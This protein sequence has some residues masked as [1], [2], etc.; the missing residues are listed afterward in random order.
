[1]KKGLLVIAIALFFLGV[2]NFYA[3]GLEQYDT[4][5]SKTT[6]GNIR[7]VNE[8]NDGYLVFYDI[9]DQGYIGMY[10]EAFN[11]KWQQPFVLD[12]YLYQ[13][14][15]NQ[16]DI[17]YGIDADGNYLFFYS[18]NDGLTVLKVD[19]EGNKI[20]QELIEGFDNVGSCK[21][22]KVDDNGYI[23]YCDSSLIKLN[24]KLKFVGGITR[25]RQLLKIPSVA[26][27]YFDNITKYIKIDNNN[28]AICGYIT[29]D[30]KKNYSCI[31]VT[32]DNITEN[33]KYTYFDN[34]PV[35]SYY[36]YDPYYGSFNYEK[37]HI[38]ITDSINGT[39][40]FIKQDLKGNEIWS[41]SYPNFAGISNIKNNT[42]LLSS[43]DEIAL[44]KYNQDGKVIKETKVNNFEYLAIDN[45]FKN[46]ITIDGDYAVV[47]DFSTLETNKIKFIEDFENG[48][49]SFIYD[50]DRGYNYI[51]LDKGHIFYSNDIFESYLSSDNRVKI[52]RNFNR[53]YTYDNN[54]Y[55]VYNGEKYYGEE[56]YGVFEV[57]TVLDK[58]E[59]INL[60][61]AYI[62]TLKFEQSYEG[63]Y[64]DLY[65]EPYM[66]E[67]MDKINKE[68]YLEEYGDI[69][70]NLFY[71]A[72]NI[73]DLE[74]LKE[75]VSL[76]NK[77]FIKEYKLFS[78]SKNMINKE[79][80]KLK[81]GSYLLLDA[82]SRAGETTVSKIKKAN[83]KVDFNSNYGK[84]KLNKNSAE[85][86]DE[87]KFE[88]IPNK[89]YKLIDF[90]VVKKN[91]PELEIDVENNKF[92][93]PNEDVVIIANFEKV[94]V[95]TTEKI[96]EEVKTTTVKDSFVGNPNTSDNILIYFVIG[97]ISFICIILLLVLN[98]KSKKEA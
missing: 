63:S 81:D 96:D 32:N 94:N 95:T 21:L 25:N 34:Y 46:L 11:L 38:I 82:D 89:G 91:H 67:L 68:F 37:D 48:K 40:Y 88:I 93:M 26:E 74:A 3:I 75:K 59:A 70:H 9:Q 56:W 77:D 80:Y 64:E 78:S 5:F 23:I 18:V 35:L 51:T 90:K 10:D 41:N 54:F 66:I 72:G 50:Y 79:I 39:S 20:S 36:K 92:N 65:N 97:G 16:S 27:S 7:E 19:K 60:I 13:N 73:D 17:N 15:Q 22:D 12:R 98:K 31:K 85:L 1:M 24:K 4:V 69:Y 84:L 8:L 49:H 14:H 55:A 29:K 28:V 47:Y 52:Y 53:N 83:Y 45:R 76:V 61:D 57:L 87:I 86:G 30:S 44:H 62:A 43:R 42:I 71:H 6:N 2:S 58:N 33:F